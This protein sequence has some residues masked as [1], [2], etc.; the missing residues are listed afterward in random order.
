MPRKGTQPSACL[1]T[2]PRPSAITCS[3]KLPLF[4]VCL[5]TVTRPIACLDKVP[6]PSTMTC[7]GKVPRLSAWQDLVPRSSAM[8]SKGA[9]V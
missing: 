7:L 5:E 1:D 2:E 4:S 9:S 8:P 6:R 3:E